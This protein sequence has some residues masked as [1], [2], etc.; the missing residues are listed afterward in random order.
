MELKNYLVELLSN[1]IHDRLQALSEVKADI[2]KVEEYKNIEE[3]FSDVNNVVNVDDDEL[4]RV[5]STITDDETIDGIISNVDMIKIVVNGMNDGLDLSLDDSQS[6]LVHGV[7]EIVNNY[8]VEMEEK[9]NSTKEYLEEFLSKCEQLSQEIGTGVVRNI[10]TLNEIFKENDVSIDD[11]IKSKYEIL[12]NNSLNYNL[13]LEGHVKEEVDLRIALKSIN[14]DLDSYSNIERKLFVTYS[15]INSVK[16]LID[17]ISE[18][19]ISLDK[20]DLLL[21]LLF[22]NLSNFKKVYELSNEYGFDFNKLF[23]MPGVF[24][25]S[26]NKDIISNVINENREDEEFYIIE[27]LSNI[28]CYFETFK[29]NIS[30]LNA[31][32]M[33]VSECFNSNMLS[34]I[35]PDMAKNIA[36]LSDLNLSNKDFGIVVINPFLATS[37]S[38]FKDYGL[39]DYVKDNP[40]R[41]TTSYYRLRNINSNIIDARKNGKIIFRSLS[42][43]KTYW[44][45][46]HITRTSSEVK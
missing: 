23:M 3:L 21:I 17:F 41:L 22:S 12:R 7:Y 29:V 24:I 39:S 46:K 6:E 14:I 25:S 9:D 31:N 18:K 8:R 5:L 11:I 35:I 40:I 45:A 13:N 2:K 33:N 19:N 26:S 42:D 38:S 44:L 32:S 30:I 37:I 15:D 28:G 20:F 4:R 36:I 16:E 1:I 10:D 27:R 34:L 43:K